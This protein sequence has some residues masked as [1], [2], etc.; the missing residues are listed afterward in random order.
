MSTRPS[1][2]PAHLFNPISSLSLHSLHW[3]RMKVFCQSLT[4]LTFA[5]KSFFAPTVPSLW[6]LLPYIMTLPHHSSTPY[7][8][9]SMERWSLIH[10]QSLSITPPSFILSTPTIS[11]W[12]FLPHQFM[13]L[14][15]A[16]NP[17]ILPTPAPQEKEACQFVSLPYLRHLKPCLALSISVNDLSF[18]RWK[19]K[20]QGSI[21][22]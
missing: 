20:M 12:N 4:N 19:P 10:P 17:C 9:V 2:A 14:L 15:T 11:S 13:R 16:S 18:Y 8:P 1:V 22:A 21:K 7:M 3:E 6:K 5:F